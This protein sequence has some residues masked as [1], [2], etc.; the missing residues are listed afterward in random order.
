MGLITLGVFAGQAGHLRR[1]GGALLIA[2]SGAT[3]LLLLVARFPLPRPAPIDW[4][5]AAESRIAF[6]PAAASRWNLLPVMWTAIREHPILGSGFGHTVTYISND[7]RIREVNPSG[8]Y[9]TY[10]LEWGWLD[11]WLKLGLI[12][13]IGIVGLIGKLS[14]TLW[15]YAS[16]NRAA[17]VALAVLIVLATIHFFTPYLN[18]PLGLG[19]L[20]LISGMLVLPDKQGY[21]KLKVS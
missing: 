6:E 16:N 14:Y 12:G 17:L 5:A 15:R 19:I 18:H 20:I 10:A 2:L 4:S 11:I 1:M 8:Q 13:L 3:L 9:T 7:P 21:G